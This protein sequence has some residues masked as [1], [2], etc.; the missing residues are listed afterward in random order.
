MQPVRL[1]R[2]SSHQEVQGLLQV[3]TLY[4]KMLFLYH[5]FYHIFCFDYT[6]IPFR[7]MHIDE[8]YIQ[9]AFVRLIPETTATIIDS[10]QYLYFVPFLQFME[11]CHD[12]ILH[13]EFYT[14]L[15]VL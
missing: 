11:K 14:L 13:F 1:N 4:V 6:E 8:S 5:Q 9:V 7:A 3:V 2:I 12:S 10:H 15:S